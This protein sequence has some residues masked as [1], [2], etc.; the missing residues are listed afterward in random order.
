MSLECPAVRKPRKRIQACNALR[1]FEAR[2]VIG[3]LRGQLRDRFPALIHHLLHAG[4]QGPGAF[5]NRPPDR[6]DV[7][8]LSD[9]AELVGKAPYLARTPFIALAQRFG[10]PRDG[11]RDFLHFTL[12]I[13]MA[14]MSLFG[15]PRKFHTKLPASIFD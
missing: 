12:V 13:A 5:E 11:G 15:P 1:F 10:H 3:D 4:A 8:Q 9:G 2:T 6:R 7:V 14:L